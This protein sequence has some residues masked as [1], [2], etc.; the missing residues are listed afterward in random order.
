MDHGFVM[1][2]FFVCARASIKSYVGDW[3]QLFDAAWR[4]LELL[5]T[6][7]TDSKPTSVFRHTVMIRLLFLPSGFFW[8]LERLVAYI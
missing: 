5:L 4:R 8:C 3:R 6:V 2:G 7:Q 1:N